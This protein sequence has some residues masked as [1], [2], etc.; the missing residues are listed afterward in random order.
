MVANIQLDV[1]GTTIPTNATFNV[2]SDVD[3]YTSL[4]TTKTYNELNNGTTVSV[5]DGSTTIRLSPNSG[6]DTFIDISIDQGDLSPAIT[7]QF[8][9]STQA[10][11]TSVTGN[12]KSEIYTDRNGYVR[13]STNNGDTF[14]SESLIPT[15]YKPATAK[16]SLLHNGTDLLLITLDSSSDT[17]NVYSV[18]NYTSGF[19]SA[20]YTLLHSQSV[21]NQSITLDN[22]FYINNRYYI[23]TSI[24]TYRSLSITDGFALVLPEVSLQH[25]DN[26]GKHVYGVKYD[27]VSG[28]GGVYKSTDNGLN[29]E[30]SYS[31]ANPI[32]IYVE[33]YTKHIVLTANDNGVYAYSTDG[34]LNYQFTTINAYDF[35]ID[36]FVYKYNSVYILKPK[37]YML[38]SPDLY[39]SSPTIT[40]VGTYSGSSNAKNNMFHPQRNSITFANQDDIHSYLITNT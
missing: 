4:I 23:A 8:D 22:T 35:G 25:M 18:T 10:F 33:S 34:G 11:V 13:I 32:N 15:L 21:P 5:S 26:Y 9:T 28:G 31:L 39:T 36:A 7:P 20:T 27:S 17:L 14:S 29:W 38:Y 1:I 40:Q 24:G 6:C 3:G 37:T 12:K 19:N 2:Y 30:Y 16:T